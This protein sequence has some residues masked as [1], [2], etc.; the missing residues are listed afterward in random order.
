MAHGKQRVDLHQQ[1]KQTLAAKE[2]FGESKY[3]A[4]RD[5]SAKDGIYSYSTAHIY[6]RECQKFARYVEEHSPEGRYT[7]LENARSY[8]KEYIER[9]NADMSKSAYTV[10][11]ERSALAKL[12]GIESKNVNKE[13][14]EVR[15]RARVDISRSR[16]RTVISEKTGKEIKNQSTRAGHFSERKHAD[17]VN[18]ARGTGMRRSEMEQVRGDQLHQRADGSYYF[19]MDGNQCNGGREREIPVRGDIERI[20]ELCERAGHDKVFERV[21]KAMDVHH[22]RSEYASNLYRELARERDAIP[23]NDRYCC[24][25]DLK[26]VWYDKVA[27]KEVSEALGHSRISVIA[28]H[29]L[30]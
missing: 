30:R 12:Y 1:V 28:E 2:R 13:L 8:A 19:K 6:N 29:Y 20:K 21:P 9:E 17:E 24:R 4:K 14:G 16:E 15:E 18:W 5:G 11:L 25:S 7:S 3:E 23:K 10:K 26:G 27:M 22:Y